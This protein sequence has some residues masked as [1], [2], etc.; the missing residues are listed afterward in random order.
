MSAL[1]LGYVLVQTLP[2]FTGKLVFG[3]WGSVGESAQRLGGTLQFCLGTTA[4]A[5]DITGTNG[6]CSFKPRLLTIE[7]QRGS[8][9]VQGGAWVSCHLPIPYRALPPL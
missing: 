7:F 9:A 4:T 2:L 8:R 6:L 1:S 5:D 3:G